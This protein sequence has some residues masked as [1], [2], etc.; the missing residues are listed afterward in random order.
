MLQWF[1][2]YAEFATDV[3][4]QS[5]DETLQRRF[6]M[7]LCLHCSGEFDQLS[8]EEL[9]F[10]LR[11]TADELARTKEVFKQKRFLDSNGK[12][13][14]WNKRQFKSDSSTER[15][16]EHRQRQR[17][18]DETLQERPQRQ[19]QITDTDR[20]KNPSASATPANGK[21]VSRETS[22]EPE[23]WLDFKLAY[24]DR[25]GDQGWRKAQRAAHARMTE[26][27]T[28]DEF[29]HG[30]KRYSEFCAATRKTGTEFVKQ[31][32]SFLGP[33]KP[34]LLPWTIPKNRAEQQQ[35]ANIEASLLWLRES[36][37]RDAV[38]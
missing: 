34:F 18:G 16:R 7:F 12:I 35:D 25:S 13:R 3:K 28:P 20:S 8:D 32:C 31:A 19:I 14:S 24:P 36:E 5:M 17:N 38:G 27:H 1:R 21:T 9:A 29:L 4:V 15:V 33:D 10:A 26:G 23:W 30:A 11:I 6:I 22:T 37:A 2:M